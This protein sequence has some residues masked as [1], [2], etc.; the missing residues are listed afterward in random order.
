VRQRP[1][2][3][4]RQASCVTPKDVPSN[5]PHAIAFRI[6]RRYR[7]LFRSRVVNWQYR[8]LLWYVCARPV[9]RRY[10]LKYPQ[11]R[12]FGEQ[13]ARWRKSERV[14]RLTTRAMPKATRRLACGSRGTALRAAT[15]SRS[16][17]QSSRSS[18]SHGG[19]QFQPLDE[20]ERTVGLLRFVNAG[21]L[22]PAMVRRAG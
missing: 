22:A 15:T 18:R 8:G 4:K 16:T 14:G 13:S 19:K 20:R 3:D 17:F 7:R 21:A 6:L 11:H 1:N 10:L 2:F 5:R 12:V 9:P